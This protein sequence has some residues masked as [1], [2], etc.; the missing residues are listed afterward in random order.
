MQHLTWTIPLN[1]HLMKTRTRQFNADPHPGNYKF[2][3]DG[4]VTFLDHGCVQEANQQKR[5][6]GVATHYAACVRDH[7]A[8]EAASR[9][10][11]KLRG[12]VF[13]EA[14][15]EYLHEAFKPQTQSPYRIE[16]HYVAG[17]A[18][19]FK[20]IFNVARSSKDDSYVPFDEGVF[21]FNRLQFGFYS[22]LARLDVEVDYATNELAFL[23]KPEA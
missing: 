7:A 12:G 9:R 17:L 19:R 14:A 1:S 13:E 18:K 23:P 5:D 10:M 4:R 11:L 3:E 2:H 21:F 20:E 15:L 22:V 6:E 16:R 8:F